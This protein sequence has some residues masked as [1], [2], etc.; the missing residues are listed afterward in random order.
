MIYSS[1]VPLLS[2]LLSFY[3]V[4]VNTLHKKVLLRE[5]KSHTDRGISS[6]PSVI[7]YEVPPPPSVRVLP[8]PRPGLMGGTRGGVPPRSGY[9]PARSKGGTQGGVPP[10][11]GYPPAR[12]KGDSQGE[13][14]PIGVPMRIPPPPPARSDR[15][16]YPRSL[17]LPGVPP[18][19]WPD[20]G[21]PPPPKV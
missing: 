7:L 8:P 12:S 19:V 9:S 16:G 1:S 20:R 2:T 11:S 10:R 5:R 21:T 14:P 3:P 17:D 18:P 15:G 13:V 6:T 4:T